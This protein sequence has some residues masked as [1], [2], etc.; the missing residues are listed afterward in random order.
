MLTHDLAVVPIIT[1]AGVAVLPALLAG[2]GSVVALIF[3]P[4]QLMALCI[5]KPYVPV[6]AL[7]ILAAAGAGV[8]WFMQP[9]HETAQ[10][11]VA[12]PGAAKT[13]WTKVAL[14]LIRQEKLAGQGIAASQPANTHE[15]PVSAGTH[16]NRRGNFARTGHL[17]GPSPRNLQP[18][19]EYSAGEGTYYFSD[20]AIHGDRIFAAGWFQDVTG[21]YGV[22][23]CMNRTGKK[24]WEVKRFE[25]TRE[26][27][28]GF[29]SSPVV[30]GDG[31]YV[32]IGQGLHL[33]KNCDFACFDAATGKLLW[34]HRTPHNHI[35]SSPAIFGDLA[36]IGA[37]AIEKKDGSPPD[38]GPGVVLAVQISTGKMLWTFNMVDPESSPAIGDDGIVYIGSGLNGK[39]VFALRSETDAELKAKGLNRI[40]WQRPV[41]HPATGVV[42]LYGDKL[43]IGIGNGDFVNADP[44]PAGAVICLHRKTGE[45]LWQTPVGDS[46][47][48]AI[49]VIGDTAYAGV[50]NGA[51]KALRLSDGHVLWS[52]SVS[53]TASLL[54]SVAATDDTLYAVANDGTLAVLNR[55][56]GKILQTV[57][58]NSASTP[59]VEN[60][61]ISS[62]I[63]ADGR[64]YVG[65]ETGGLR[66]FIGSKVAP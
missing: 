45:V 42:T 50:R 59:G 16:F 39:A 61:S 1:N 4:R 53:T 30:T 5:K 10:S 51:V 24:I 44:N 15:A 52:Q 20:P 41:E 62:P 33:D 38:E 21:M 17:G 47:L 26:R 36:V 55:T 57:Q 12:T 27:L 28:K 32:L 54:A 46:V 58:V 23:T 34:R 40:L 35:E 66:C 3:K 19:F 43:L 22:F 31:K 9:A 63:I 64:V 6:L 65:S 48:G 18:L 49:A 29:F 11:E 37:G 7:L 13:D 8:W 56:D 2:L 60:L 25:D 14:E